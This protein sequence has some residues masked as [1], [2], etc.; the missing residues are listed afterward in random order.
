M[1]TCAPFG[2]LLP[3][4][5]DLVLLCRY[6]PFKLEQFG[7]RLVQFLP[8]CVAAGVLRFSVGNETARASL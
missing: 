6:Q 2:K 5:A 3:Q 4:V 7:V 8:E 1:D